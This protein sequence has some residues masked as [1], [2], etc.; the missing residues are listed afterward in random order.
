[1][2]KRIIVS[3]SIC[4]RLQLVRLPPTNNLCFYR[5]NYLVEKNEIVFCLDKINEIKGT[6]ICTR[7]S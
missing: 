4:K 6:E 5:D 3:F 1:M 7:K 2:K